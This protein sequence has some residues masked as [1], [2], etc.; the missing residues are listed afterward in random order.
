MAN[1]Y[2]NLAKIII[3]NVGGTS[4]V[5]SVAHCATRLRF[6]LKD[7]SKANDEVLK[8][9][10]GVVT[11][12]KAAGQYQIVI[13]NEVADVYDAVL[14][15]GNFSGEGEVPED[16]TEKGNIIDRLIDLISGIFTP[17]L[18]P[19]CAAGMIKGLT[20][21]AISFRWLSA[22]S[23]AYKVLYA[24]GDGFFYFLPLIL[25]ITAAKK[26]RINQFTAIAIGAA[27]CY[28]AI[29]AL[30]SDKNVLMT[31]FKGTAFQSE[32]H[33][34]FFGIPMISMNYAS[35]VIPII[36]AV[37]FASVIEKWCKTWIPTVVK[38]F[39]VPFVT[40]LIVVPITFLVIGPVAT[41]IGDGLAA[42]TSSIYN[43]SPVLAGIVLGAFWQVFVIFGVHWGFVAVMMTNIAAMGYDPIIALTLGASFAQ[44]GVVLAI[45]FQ[46]KDTKLKAIALPAFI[47]GIFGITEPA[48]YGVTLPRKKPFVLSCIAS[49]I[50]GGML[51]LFGTKLYMLGGLGIFSIP[52]AISPKA[53]VNM[54]VYG[55]IIAM[56]V[57]FVLG[58][59][60]QFIFGK[61]SVNTPQN[62]D[63]SSIVVSKTDL[64][65]PLD[66][67][68]LPLS[69]IKDEVFSSGAMGNGIAID[70][71]NDMLHA[72][73][74]GEIIMTF[75]TSHAIGMRTDD[76]VEVLIHLGM[77][78][79]NLNGKN[80]KTL[81]QKG[82][83]VKVG[84]YLIKFDLDA[85]KKAGYS[86][87][88]PIVITNSK[89]YDIH[90]DARGNIKVG[91]KIMELDAIT[92]E[93]TDSK[94]KLA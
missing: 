4:N 66:G 75:P 70:P 25:A 89:N 50:G 8:N 24:I 64:V 1:N 29:T 61:D 14:K 57:S 38:T 80:F 72:P 10:D 63:S 73:A 62:N 59:I 45:F 55:M 68:V 71:T 11:V 53:G 52:S 5:V 22:N 92:S 48:I 27:M 65:S 12:V 69:E 37:W 36:L 60:F 85:I 20:A 79:V 43:F 44:I 94:P 31:L 16:E 87:A 56:A 6:K 90:V 21:M 58:L 86:M 51:G 35:T 46:A 81:V 74:N 82:Q 19:M 32:I 15:I 17:I 41:W 47:A 13:G 76:G 26:F 83:K 39:L 49:A 23:G 67:K 9:T 30:A 42:L 2:D 77:D 84:D 33:A 88:T 28:P 34:T 91:Q 93:V 18:G 3:K 54:S 78:T 7:E 40:L